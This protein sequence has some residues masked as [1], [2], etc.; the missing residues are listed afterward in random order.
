MSGLIDFDDIFWE[1]Y[2]K[3]VPLGGK[4]VEVLIALILILL[5][6]HGY[7]IFKFVVSIE[8]ALFTIL[9]L[10]KVDGVPA[11]LGFTL[12]IAVGGL[13]FI[14]YES[15]LS[16]IAFVFAVFIAIFLEAMICP[17]IDEVLGVI[18]II[19]VATVVALL[20]RIYTKS[21]II[22]IT[23][24]QFGMMAGKYIDYF[25]GSPFEFFD[26][27]A[28]VV[29]VVIAIRRQYRE[30]YNQF[31]KEFDIKAA[32]DALARL[33]AEGTLT[34][35]KHNDQVNNSV[36]EV[37]KAAVP[38][39]RQE[40]YTNAETLSAIRQIL[41]ATADIIRARL[42][43]FSLKAR[44]LKPV[45]GLKPVTEA[46]KKYRMIVIA[47]LICVVLIVG[48]I[49]LKNHIPA[50]SVSRTDED[51]YSEYNYEDEYEDEYYGY[52]L[53]EDELA[54]SSDYRHS[55]KDIEGKI[56]SIIS[57]LRSKDTTS[58]ENTE[59]S[60][61]AAQREEIDKYIEKNHLREIRLECVHMEDEPVLFAVLGD[62]YAVN[63]RDTYLQ[64]VAIDENLKMYE[65]DRIDMFN[66][67][68]EL[69]WYDS[70]SDAILS[71]DSGNQFCVGV[72]D[73]IHSFQY[74]YDRKKGIVYQT[75]SLIWLN[76]YYCGIYN[77]EFMYRDGEYIGL[78][79][80]EMYY[81]GKEYRPYK[82]YEITEEELREECYNV[83]ETKDI[84][85]NR[86]FQMDSYAYDEYPGRVVSAD[87]YSI[88][89]SRNDKYYLTFE[90]KFEF[91]KN[92]YY[93]GDPEWTMYCYYE[94]VNKGGAL[95]AEYPEAPIGE[96]YSSTGKKE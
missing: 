2:E 93:D 60:I 69:M 36:S 51:E 16:V 33:G 11:V 82:T 28:G 38:V 86:L 3:T 84:C 70:Y 10:S 65:F 13:S 78:A 88:K 61:Q 57:E 77:K 31:E 55:E 68:K 50:K 27:I 22:I 25:F 49:A 20:V 59:E 67:Y 73:D 40:E 52:D 34:S 44:S 7:K 37:D 14:F 23:S 89:K 43:I 6:L 41:K 54:D 72:Y 1:A 81:D 24:L 66:E 74:K 48:I 12:G 91:D 71:F 90:Y 39:S 85:I 83:Q 56:V 35:E 87:L 63:D 15:I 17:S 19:I 94:F 18:L 62:E 80:V 42:K 64:V 95:I 79:M 32:Q 29:V 21:I 96:F 47:A 92:E 4:V 8:V 46:I 9:L 53:D 30:Y 58:D 45:E 5:A 76:E 26:L 75:D